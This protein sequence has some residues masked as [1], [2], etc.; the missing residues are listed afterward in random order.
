LLVIYH[1]FLV[2]YDRFTV[3]YYGARYG[4]QVVCVLHHTRG[5]TLP[6]I[7]IYYGLLVIYYGLQ[8][9]YDKLIGTAAHFCEVV[10]LK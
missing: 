2:I 5:P 3:I 10:V 1:G 8:V 6:F 9:I 4:R 7:V